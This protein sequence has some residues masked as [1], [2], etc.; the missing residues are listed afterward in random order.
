MANTEQRSKLT[1][2]EFGQVE[3]AAYANRQ[4]REV[5]LLAMRTNTPILMVSSP[6]C[7][8]TDNQ[9]GRVQAADR[10]LQHGSNATS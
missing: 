5:P 9:V 6:L 8:L 10:L 2:G 3:L 4:Y 7:L 1:T